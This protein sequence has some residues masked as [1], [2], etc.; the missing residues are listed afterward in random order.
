VLTSEARLEASKTRREALA[1]LSN[2]ETE[3]EAVTVY[4][5]N[6]AN[7]VASSQQKLAKKK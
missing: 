5:D 3:R 6:L 2:Y 4:I 1:E 7:L